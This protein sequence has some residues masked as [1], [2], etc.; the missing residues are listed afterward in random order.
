MV[1]DYNSK[2]NLGSTRAA[3]RNTT[4]QDGI[5]L[6]A[7]VLKETKPSVELLHLKHEK[8]NQQSKV[9]LDSQLMLGPL[10]S[11]RHI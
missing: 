7:K 10:R 4:A 9:S 8:R 2:N 3:S 5:W 11:S 1:F 6:T